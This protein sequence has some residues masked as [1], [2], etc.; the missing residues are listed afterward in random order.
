MKNLHSIGS[1]LMELFN[2]P[3]RDSMSLGQKAGRVLLVT[4]TLVTLSVI[5]ALVL[6]LV[7]FSI[8]S[9]GKVLASVPNFANAAKILLSS[10]AVNVISIMLLFQVRRFD[11]RLM[12]TGPF[13]INSPSA[14]TRT[15][16]QL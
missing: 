9:G 1:W 11:H 13:G 6:A 7:L 5:V 16:K 3:L 15:E 4:V 2:P 10:I 12:G 14:E 8:D